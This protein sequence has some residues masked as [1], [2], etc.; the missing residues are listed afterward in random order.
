VFS[1][2]LLPRSRNSYLF[3]VQVLSHNT[4]HLRVLLAT[5]VTSN[6]N[7][8]PFYPHHSLTS[9]QIRGNI[10]F[11]SQTLICAKQ[12]RKTSIV[13]RSKYFTKRDEIPENFNRK[14][15][16]FPITYLGLPLTTSHIKRIHLQLVMDKLQS[17]LAEWKGKLIQ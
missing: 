10:V 15:D 14:R 6:S 2:L 8:Y 7:L 9:I 12:P 16:S 1:I 11:T 17:R 3:G 13:G 4:C 5:S